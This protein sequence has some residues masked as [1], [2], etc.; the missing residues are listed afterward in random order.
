MK[1]ILATLLASTVLAGATTIKINS[2][3]GGV[4]DFS[5]DWGPSISEYGAMAA[6]SDG[7]TA[8]WMTMISRNPSFYF[9]SVNTDAMPLSKGFSIRFWLDPEYTGA[10]PTSF[11]S[12][13]IFISSVG[14]SPQ[15]LPLNGNPYGA[16]F[17]Y[18]SPDGGNVGW[19]MAL[20]L[21]GIVLARKIG[22]VT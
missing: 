14:P 17:V 7:S 10:A 5:V 16:R 11:G 15:I 2:D 21:V 19:M 1:T 9:I 20:G 22:A 12:T 13:N 4:F 18:A 3:T 8:H 6:G